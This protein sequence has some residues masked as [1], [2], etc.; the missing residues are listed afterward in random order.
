M[1]L[2]ELIEQIVSEDTSLEYFLTLR[3]GDEICVKG[4]AASPMD[5]LFLS[6]DGTMAMIHQIAEE[7]QNTVYQVIDLVSAYLRDSVG[8]I[9]KV[10]NERM[11]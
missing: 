10:K 5:A 6:L 2:S 1:K 4:T 11:Q 9:G 8:N 3:Q 7:K